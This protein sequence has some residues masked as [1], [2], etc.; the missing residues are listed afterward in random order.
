MYRITTRSN[1][2]KMVSIFFTQVYL[3]RVTN[4]TQ[5]L[6][7]IVSKSNIGRDNYKHKTV[8]SY[9][10]TLFQ[11]LKTKT[12]VKHAELRLSLVIKLFTKILS[13]E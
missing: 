8:N 9:K 1:Y 12:V 7:F 13:E 2:H 11:S 3:H 10:S 6:I 5:Q 4:K